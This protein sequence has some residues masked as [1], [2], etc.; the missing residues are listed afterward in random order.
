M[1]P[2][3]HWNPLPADV[4]RGMHPERPLGWH[5]Y[6]D[7]WL[8]G[9]LG[10]FLDYG[11]GPG[12]LLRR[13]APRCDEAWGVDVDHDTLPVSTEGFRVQAIAPD[14]PLPFE[15]GHFDTVSSLEVLEHVADEGRMLGE[16]ARVLRPGGRLVLTT[17]HK[18]LLT[19][20]DPANF[21]FVLPR[22]HRLIHTGVLGDRAYYDGRF[23]DARR[24]ERK[25]LGDF[26]LDQDPW[27]RHYRLADVLR[28]VPPSLELVDWAVYYPGMRASWVASV[29]LRV[30]SRGRIGAT[31]KWLERIKHDLS[32][33][34]TMLGDQLVM[35][36]R[37]R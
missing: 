1:A 16:L 10:R 35:R 34:E 20:L 30:L 2:A 13:V 5:D 33:R 36:F 11:C 27:H 26:T 15:D 28:F 8:D 12:I 37:R 4:R 21:K 22:A 23:G 9:P 25:M 29:G 18:G 6:A 3:P 32:R 14:A 19:W 17:P 24:S 7:A 31:P